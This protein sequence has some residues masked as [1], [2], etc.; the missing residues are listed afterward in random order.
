MQVATKGNTITHQKYIH[1]EYRQTEGISW[2]YRYNVSV[3]PV[4][5]LVEHI[6]LNCDMHRSWDLH[7]FTT[8]V[9]GVQISAL[10]E[11]Y[12]LIVWI[13]YKYRPISRCIGASQH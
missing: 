7:Y 4:Q 9:E 13:P 8:L 11:N 12:C 1:G 2:G 5:P 6:L 10:E 3:Q